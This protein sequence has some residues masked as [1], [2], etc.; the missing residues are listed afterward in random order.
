MRNR[1][2]QRDSSILLYYSELGNHEEAIRIG[3]RAFGD[4]KKGL[5]G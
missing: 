5:W 4:Y 2:M 3:T 1:T